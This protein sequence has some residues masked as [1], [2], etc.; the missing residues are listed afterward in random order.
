MCLR[1]EVSGV[2]NG[3]VYSAYDSYKRI[4]S[5]S[6]S[7]N[8]KSDSIVG[9]YSLDGS[10]NLILDRRN[11]RLMRPEFNTGRNWTIFLEA[12]PLYNSICH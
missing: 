9:E 7:N 6:Q 8:A 11:M 5:C 10:S 1:F 3:T 2:V 4:G 12:K